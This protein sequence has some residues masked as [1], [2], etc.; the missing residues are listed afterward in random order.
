MNPSLRIS[1]LLV[2][3]ANAG[4]LGSD[5]AAGERKSASN[6]VQSEGVGITA[7]PIQP[8]LDRQSTSPKEWKLTLQTNRRKYRPGE[9]IELTATL[10]NVTEES[11][12]LF[13]GA[14]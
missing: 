8:K 12:W 3:L 9:K 7:K 6:E 5:T 1:A 4:A 14:F 13:R 11:L 10:V 2:V